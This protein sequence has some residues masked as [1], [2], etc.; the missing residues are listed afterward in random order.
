MNHL[1][2]F[3]LLMGDL[4][5]HYFQ[6]Q[7]KKNLSHDA[8]ELFYDYDDYVI[9]IKFVTKMTLTYYQVIILT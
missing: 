9:D 5:N 6:Y 4:K 8:E 7:K 1:F 3:I 2:L